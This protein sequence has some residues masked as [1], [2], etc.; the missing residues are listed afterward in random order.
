MHKL[1]SF[2]NMR[3]H[4]IR[5]V[6]AAALV[7]SFARMA[8]AQGEEHAWT[9]NIGAGFTALVGS[10]N[11]RLDNGWNI[12]FGAGYNLSSRVSLGAQVMYNGLS[13]SN[14]VLQEFRVPDG[15]ARIWA[16]TAEP[17]LNFAP[18]RKFTPYIV[19]GVGYYRRVVEFTQPTLVAVNVFD[20]FFFTFN[21]VLIR[22]NV[23][24]GRVIRDGVGGSAGAGFQ[25]PIGQSGFKFF[26]EARFHYAGDGGVPTRMAPFTVGLRY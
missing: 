18:R 8:A 19:G 22:A 9:A 16:I 11:T 14:G 15:N 2:R 4:L 12:S 6:A 26:A 23:V 17:R 13:V 3:T 10:M 21:P 24:L 25:I 7:V 1:I 5:L 20:P